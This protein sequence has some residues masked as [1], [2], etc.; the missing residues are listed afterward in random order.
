MV[1]QG[2]WLGVLLATVACASSQ[3]SPRV[4]GPESCREPVLSLPAQ[5]VVVEGLGSLRCSRARSFESDTG[6]RRE[7]EEVIEYGAMSCMSGCP[8]GYEEQW[9]MLRVALHPDGS[10]L[11][12]D[13][14][15]G[16]LDETG[17]FHSSLSLVRWDPEGRLLNARADNPIVVR[18]REGRLEFLVLGQVEHVLTVEGGRLLVNGRACGTVSGAATPHTSDLALRIVLL[19]EFVR[20]SSAPVVAPLD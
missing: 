9:S 12:G 6:E 5:P 16:R 10:V 3:E 15:V 18:L 7:D 17:C 8:E 19:P 1:A 11:Y 20:Y 2:R 13:H 14:V 4:V